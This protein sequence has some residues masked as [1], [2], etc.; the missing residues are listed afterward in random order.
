[1]DKV[2]AYKLIMVTSQPCPSA[3]LFVVDIEE[4]GDPPC[5]R[6]GRPNRPLA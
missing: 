3:L 4:E 1:L 5:T 6:L 2:T